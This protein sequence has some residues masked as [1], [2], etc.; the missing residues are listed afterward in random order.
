[1]NISYSLSQNTDVVVTVHDQYSGA[2][3][4]IP[5]ANQNQNIGTHTITYSST[6]LSNGIYFIRAVTPTSVDVITFIVNH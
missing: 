3:M 1:M 2:L 4:G 6:N 5:Q